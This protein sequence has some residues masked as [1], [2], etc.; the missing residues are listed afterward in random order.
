MRHCRLS[1]QINCTLL[2][3]ATGDQKQFFKNKLSQGAGINLPIS[4][5]KSKKFVSFNSILCFRVTEGT[6]IMH[7]DN[8][9]TNTRL[10]GVYLH[11]HAHTFRCVWH[12]LFLG[13]CASHSHKHKNTPTQS[14]ADGRGG[15][16]YLREPWC[17]LSRCAQEIKIGLL[18][19]L[20]FDLQSFGNL[21]LCLLLRFAA[22]TRNVKKSERLFRVCQSERYM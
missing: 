4:K 10:F 21:D 19:T 7:T 20:H 2:L 8:T 15:S 6:D 3:M 17:T 18:A 5:K 9:F 11:N 14:Q 22:E 1:K 12:A 16:L 13:L